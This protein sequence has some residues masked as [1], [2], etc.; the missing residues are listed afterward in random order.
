MAGAVAGAKAPSYRE[1]ELRED[2]CTYT[3]LH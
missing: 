3:R 1:M 2:P